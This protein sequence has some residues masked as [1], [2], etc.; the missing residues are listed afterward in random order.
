MVK[1]TADETLNAAPKLTVRRSVSTALKSNARRKDVGGVATE[2]LPYDFPEVDSRPSSTTSDDA[3]NVSYSKKDG[4]EMDST[5]A[6]AYEIEIDITDSNTVPDK[7][8]ASL[9]S[10]VVKAQDVGSGMR[11]RW[12]TTTTGLRAARTPSSWTRS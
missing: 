3:S 7:G 2:Q 12:V 11:R 10:I 6:R 4:L 8:N 1:V 5:G 9:I